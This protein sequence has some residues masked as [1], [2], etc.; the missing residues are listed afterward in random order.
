MIAALRYRAMDLV[1]RTPDER[2]AELPGYPW[3]PRYV[4]IADDEVGPMRMHYVDA[5]PPDADPVLLLHGQPTW[6]YLYRKVIAELARQGHRVVAPDNIG[7]GR[8]DKPTDRLAYSLEGHIGWLASL[9]RSL[10]LREITGV[11]QDW[12]GPIGFGLLQTEADRFS[13][14]VAADT[15]LHTCDSWLAG[16]L[17]WAN[18][19]IDGGRIVHE[20]ALLD[21]MMATQHLRD[22]R[23]SAIV[24]SITANDLSAEEQA[25]YDAPFPDETYRAGL[26]QMNTLIPVSRNSPGAAIC[27]ASFD[28]L[29]RWERPF[30]TVWGSDD[31]GT[32]GWE[33]VFQQEVP[34]AAGLSHQI[35]AGAGHFIQEDRGADF[36]GILSDFITATGGR[37]S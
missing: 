5:G 6:S 20:E 31:P 8:S 7:F 2:F 28:V 4:E 33:T 9:V 32:S 27:R 25:A 29:R 16:Q 17:T 37:S 30:L 10:D 11:F 23:P 12:G 36:A 21:W 22:L 14:L 24:G 26:R 34:G 35:L 13:R 1:A 18:H 19:G 15:V 3:P